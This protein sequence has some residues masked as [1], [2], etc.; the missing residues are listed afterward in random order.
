MIDMV[1]IYSMSISLLID[2]YNLLH[3]TGA[4]NLT[5]G[6]NALAKA[7]DRLLA[8]I[9]GSL[10]ETD[11]LKTQVVFDARRSGTASTLDSEVIVR[12]MTVTFAVGFHEADELLEQII[13]QHPNPKTLTVVSSDL[14]VQ[15][16]ATARKAIAIGSD[17][18]LMQALD[19][20]RPSTNNTADESE[21]HEPRSD[22][23]AEEV[24]KWLREFGW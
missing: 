2:G 22:L 21:E 24:Q 6:A 5:R 3:A 12:G 18:W 10:T 13:R 19:G 23:S 4:L 8:Q 14:R 7:R 15:R 17:G 1:T 11:R 16:C 20:P 9:A